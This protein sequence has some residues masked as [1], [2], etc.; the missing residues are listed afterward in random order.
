[1]LRTAETGLYCCYSTEGLEE[2]D[3]LLIVTQIYW[4]AA[5]TMKSWTVG[6][7]QLFTF[8]NIAVYLLLLFFSYFSYFLSR[9]SNFPT[10]HAFSDCFL[11]SA[12]WVA[13][14]V[15]YF[16]VN[17]VTGFMWRDL[18]LTWAQCGCRFVRGELNRCRRCV[19][20]L[21]EVVPVFPMARAAL[22]LLLSTGLSGAFAGVFFNHAEPCYV[23]KTRGKVFGLT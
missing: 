14:G 5:N 19:I 7:D 17:H 21:L 1:M 10:V 12:P 11:R 20:H 15:N 3:V 2:C 13:F 4:K 8:L 18:R 22:L 16:L 6:L 23:R 9:D